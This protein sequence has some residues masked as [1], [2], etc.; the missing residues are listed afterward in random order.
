MKPETVPIGVGNHFRWKPVAAI[1][2]ISCRSGIGTAL[3]DRFKAERQDIGE[4]WQVRFRSIVF[5]AAAGS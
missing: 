1:D 4:E 5:P 2:G 3:S